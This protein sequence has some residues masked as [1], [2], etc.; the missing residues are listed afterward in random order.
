MENSDMKFNIE[1]Y[2]EK[3]GVEVIETT[4]NKTKI[5]RTGKFIQRKEVFG[6]LPSIIECFLE[7]YPEI[8]TAFAMGE[9]IYINN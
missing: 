3:F 1:I 8:A 5:I 6:N 2:N 4:K 7:G 9:E